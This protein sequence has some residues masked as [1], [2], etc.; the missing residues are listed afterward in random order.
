MYLK[1]TPSAIVLLIV[2]LV[3]YSKPLPPTPKSLTIVPPKSDFSLTVEATVVRGFYSRFGINAPENNTQ[4][5]FVNIITRNTGTTAI[6]WTETVTAFVPMNGPPLV[7]RSARNSNDPPDGKSLQQDTLKFR[8]EPGHEHVRETRTNGYTESL[9]DSS[10]GAPLQLHIDFLSDG[11]SITPRFITDLPD[12]PSLP[13]EFDTQGTPKPDRKLEFRRG[14][15]KTE[16][17]D[18]EYLVT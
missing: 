3:G 16:K 4:E 10:G 11:K 9:L 18:M 7:N 8:L 15:S 2:L 17:P 12:L 14:P 1:S 5:Y 13:L 6:E